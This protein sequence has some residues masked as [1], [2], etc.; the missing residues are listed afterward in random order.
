[1]VVLHKLGTNVGGVD[2]VHLDRLVV[3][4]SPLRLPGDFRIVEDELRDRI[5]AE[6]RVDVRINDVEMGESSTSDNPTVLDGDAI[7]YDE[8]D[9]DND[10]DDDWGKRPIYQLSPH[11]ISWGVSR[12]EGK[13]VGKYIGELFDNLEEKGHDTKTKPKGVKPGKG[14]RHGGYGI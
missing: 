10:D 3:D 7:D 6:F 13:K 11:Y 9:D 4:L 2:D 12:Q 8:N 5:Y 1:M 14:R